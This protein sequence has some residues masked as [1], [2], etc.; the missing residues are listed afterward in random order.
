MLPFYRVNSE[1]TTIFTRHHDDVWKMKYVSNPIIAKLKVLFNWKNE[2]T[3]IKK[4]SNVNICTS[5]N[6]ICFAAWFYHFFPSSKTRYYDRQ[7]QIPHGGFFWKYISKRISIVCFRVI[8]I[9]ELVSRCCCSF[10]EEVRTGRNRLCWQNPFK[11]ATKWLK[12]KKKK[13]YN[14]RKSLPFLYQIGF[15]GSICKH[16][17][18][19]FEGSWTRHTLNLLISYK[20]SLLCGPYTTT[21]SLTKTMTRSF[22]LDLQLLLLSRTFMPMEWLNTWMGKTIS[23]ELGI[24]R[25]IISVIIIT[26]SHKNGSIL[27]H[28][29]AKKRK[30]KRLPFSCGLLSFCPTIF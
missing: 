30:K 7:I 16:L 29:T 13:V 10:P 23:Q 2:R 6:K 1:F 3:P 18:N 8:S 4:I 20:I 15:S 25:I 24:I 19:G 11:K 5:W 21:T 22:V 27:Q 9:S 26:N 12:I 28:S 14:F 17:E